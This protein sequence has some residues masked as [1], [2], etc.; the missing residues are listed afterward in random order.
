M[1]SD[2]IAPND[3]TLRVCWISAKEN[4]KAE[5]DPETSKKC[6]AFFLNRTPV[7]FSPR[8]PLEQSRIQEIQS[9]R[10]QGSN[11]LKADPTAIKC[12]QVADEMVRSAANDPKHKP[13]LA[14]ICE[15]NRLLGQKGGGRLRQEGDAG[16]AAGGRTDFLYAPSGRVKEEMEQLV[17]WLN[18]ALK[19]CKKG[20]LNPIETAGKAYQ[21]IVSIHPF[22]DQNGRTSRMVMDYVLQKFKLPPA[23]MGDDILVAFFSFRDSG[24]NPT[25]ATE[26]VLKGVQHSYEILYPTR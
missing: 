24:Q 7:D 23:A 8:S 9:K 26:A 20:E 16:V 4:F 22:H 12:W 1:K 18:F 2:G 19:Q 13:T 15:I 10:M 14:W 17:G 21:R 11:T 25:T 3:T 5:I 6:H